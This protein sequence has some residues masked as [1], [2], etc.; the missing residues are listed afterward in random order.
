MNRTAIKEE[1]FCLETEAG[2]VAIAMQNDTFRRAVLAGMPTKG[3]LVCTQGVLALD[4]ETY[5]DLLLSFALFTAFDEGNDPYGEHNFLA[6][7]IKGETYFAKIDYYADETLTWG[8]ED[9]GDPDQTYRVLTVM[10][11]CEY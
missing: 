8:S 11:A 10:R 9:P 6:V 4:I 2:A 5:R 1:S 7:K 3:M